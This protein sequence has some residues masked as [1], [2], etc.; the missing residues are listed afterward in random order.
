M[1]PIIGELISAPL[2]QYVPPSNVLL[3]PFQAQLPIQGPLSLF[4]SLLGEPSQILLFLR[5]YTILIGRRTSLGP[6]RSLST[7]SGVKS[8]RG[9]VSKATGRS[10]NSVMK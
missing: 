4:L 6:N 7:M 5:V 10:I 2:P 8:I 1:G 9:S 3:I